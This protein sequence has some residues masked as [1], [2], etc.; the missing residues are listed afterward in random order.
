[1]RRDNV[2]STKIATAVATPLFVGLLTS[3]GTDPDTSGGSEDADSHVIEQ[4]D[5]RDGVRFEVM[6][7][8]RGTVTPTGADKRGGGQSGDST[9]LVEDG[10][11]EHVRFRADGNPRKQR[12]YEGSIVVS[13][14][15]GTCHTIAY[16]T[17]DASVLADVESGETQT[18]TVKMGDKRIVDED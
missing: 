18:F 12:A 4:P 9:W 17:Y 5:K 1:L 15:S 13:P 10:A 16:S 6:C 8:Q 3:C 2:K 14:S 11:T 7:G